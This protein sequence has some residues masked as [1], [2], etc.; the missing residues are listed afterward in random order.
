[1][2]DRIDKRVQVRPVSPAGRVGCAGFMRLVWTKSCPSV[3]R[4]VELDDEG[5]ALF[6]R[7]LLLAAL[8]GRAAAGGPVEARLRCLRGA[9]HT[10]LVL[11]VPGVDGL[12]D[13]A[14]CDATV[15]EFAEATTGVVPPGQEWQSVPDTIAVF[16]TEAEAA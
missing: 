10:M 16:E 9:P 3:V 14:L 12:T 5:E 1:M 11:T 8:D 4:L 6:S 13:L 15:R 7:D 2:T